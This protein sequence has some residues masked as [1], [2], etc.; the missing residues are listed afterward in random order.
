MQLRRISFFLITI[1]SFFCPLVVNAE[2]SG[3]ELN[4]GILDSHFKT[5]KVSVQDNFMLPPVIS[6]GTGERI[7][8]SFDE[9]GDDYSDLQYRLLHCNSDWKPSRLVESEYL[10]GF[11]NADLEDYAYSVNTFVHFVNYRIEIPNENMVPLVSG[12]YLLEVYRRDDP[13]N[14]IIRT[15]FRVVENLTRFGAGVT[16]RTDR[17]VNDRWQ[18]LAISIDGEGYDIGNPYQDIIV[19]VVQNNRKETSRKLK[20]PLRVAGSQI[21]YEHATELLFP[22][23]NEYRRFESVSNLFPGMH[24]DSLHFGGTN[25]HVY[26]AVDEPRAD[27]NYEYDRTQHGRFLVREYN[28]TDSD[29]GADYITVHFTLNTPE[30]IGKEIYVDGELTH[31]N[32]TQ[33]NR[34]DYNAEKGVYE[35]ALPLKQGAY[36]YQYV[37]RDA[38]DKGDPSPT[39]I[40]GDKYETENEY[41]IYVY[42]RPP[43]ARYDRL[44]GY[45]TV[46]SR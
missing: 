25:Y 17:G 2:G 7:I 12:N 31:G 38:G 19:E 28:S 15:P 4:T 43:G 44:I 35:L 6:L 42:H 26:L 37:V 32:Y 16:T 24:V 5:L 29:L 36:N 8:V 14:I 33:Q 10:E 11:N 9:I 45:T 46:F 40:E 34:M 30:V 27:R 23:S 21:V 20:A 13:D 3:N 39:L 22:A 18:Q 41:S 1:L